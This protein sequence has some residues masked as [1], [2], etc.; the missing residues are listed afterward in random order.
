L[1]RDWYKRAVIYCV[2]VET[3][4]DGNGD[5]YG[6]FRGL[7]AS[8][9]H[10]E[11]LGIDCIWLE[12]FYPS[13]L[14][15]NGY[16]VVDHCSVHPRMGT[17]EDFDEF[18][19]EAGRRGIA[20]LADL[21]L[22]HTSDQHPWFRSA[23]SD[24]RSQ[25]RDYYLWTDDPGDHP[26]PDAFPTDGSGP[27]T[28]DEAARCWYLHRFYAHEP[29]LNTANPRVQEEMRAIMEFW[30][31][32]GVAGFRVDASQFLVQKL[33]EAGD[34]D[35]HRILRDMRRIVSSRRPDGVLLA[36]ADVELCELPAF[37]G[38]GDEMHLLLNFYLDAYLFLALTRRQAEPVARVIGALPRIPPEGQWA[39]FIRNQ[40]ELNLSHLSD[41]E[42]EEVFATFA[43]AED[44][45]VFG[46]G[47]RRRVAP[48]LG[49]DSR[50]LELI[51][52]LLLSLPGTPVL[53]YGDEIGMGD[54][55]SLPER[56]S[57]RTPMQWA[58]SS[59]GGFSDAPAEQLIRPLIAAG[60]FGYERLNV[61]SQ[62]AEERSMLHWLET[63]IAL[64]REHHEIGRGDLRL[65]E[66]G[67]PAVLAHCCEWSD[68]RL[69][70]LHNFSDGP[71]TVS[72]SGDWSP[73]EATELL[74][75]SR[76]PSR[77]DGRVELAPSGYRWWALASGER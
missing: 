8:L 31:G 77:D 10:L 61:A 71:R 37:F 30:L 36:E 6:D 51:Y 33:Q 68:R 13:P 72:L 7:T 20:V 55:L 2:A 9:D 18:I 28:Y 42:R 29:D 40:D 57:V 16:D 49:G 67:D 58:P 3:F 26:E 69:L 54:H 25:F 1:D 34:P 14:A 17:L 64:R 66:T 19:A 38:K 41:E 44:E 43:P 46:R 11:Q 23:R 24:P 48:M 74:A 62:R 47:I 45:R 5:G 70:A 73:D 53:G 60:P 39:N 75:D 52:S 21:V 35:P 63:A 50:R 32:R 12:P 4:R 22:S 27:W 15:D 65:I 76:Y 59:G 56:L